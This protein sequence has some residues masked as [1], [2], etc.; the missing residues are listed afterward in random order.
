MSQCDRHVRPGFR[1]THDVRWKKKKKTFRCGDSLSGANYIPQCIRATS[2]HTAF[3]NLPSIPS[4][5]MQ[6]D[7]IRMY[8]LF[9]YARCIGSPPRSR[10]DRCKG[11]CSNPG[12]FPCS[13]VRMPVSTHNCRIV[14][15]RRILHH[16]G[17]H[18]CPEKNT[19]FDGPCQHF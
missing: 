18:T 1:Q 5:F 8:P 12:R 7:V 4:V 11:G 9:E 2:S 3:R 17:A 6:Q 13:W 10:S 15:R 16:S 14:R 19:V